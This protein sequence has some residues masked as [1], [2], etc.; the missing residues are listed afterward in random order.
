MGAPGV[1][2][3]DEHN[4]GL[5]PLRCAQGQNDNAKWLVE[6]VVPTLGDE[7]AKDGAPEGWWR[8]E[9]KQKQIPSLRC[10]M[11]CKRAT[12]WKCE[13]VAEWKCRKT[14]EWK[15]RKTAEWDRVDTFAAV[16]SLIR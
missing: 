9:R 13:W 5:F 11:E 8:F 12:E 16:G 3:P 7:A 4:A 10:G 1:W 2:W 6:G 14:A 15:C